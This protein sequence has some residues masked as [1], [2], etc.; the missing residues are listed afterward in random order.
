MDKQVSVI[1]PT[2]N[3]I[4][5]ISKTIDSVYNQTAKPL[6]IIVVDDGST[7]GTESFLRQKYP[8]VV[9]LRNEVSVRGAV[10][11]NQGA[12]IARGEYVAFLDS[13][14]YWLPDHLSRQLSILEEGA[15]GACSEFFLVLEGDDKKPVKFDNRTVDGNIVNKIF[16]TKPFDCRTSTFVFR[17]KKFDSVK[18]D[19]N[20]DKHQDWDL[21]LNFAHSNKLVCSYHPSVFIDVSHAG[22]RMSHKLNH[23]ASLYF[24]NKNKD[25]LT[26]DSVYFF[27]L[28]NYYYSVQNNDTNSRS[29]LQFIKKNKIKGSINNKL[30]LR[31]IILYS[32]FISLKNK[33]K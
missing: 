2:K 6:E 13:D 8:D 14:D 29:Y 26:D 4:D 23:N 11:R 28:K 33:L 24:L 21:A 30:L 15:D 18:F 9:I 25:K 32:H 1:I 19:E 10:A 16:S 22:E 20:M 5:I 27:C 3:R 17:K 7:D 12:A 31:I